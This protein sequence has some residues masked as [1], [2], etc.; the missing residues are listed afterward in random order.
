MKRY[1]FLVKGKI[2]SKLA[3]SI[4]EAESFLLPEIVNPVIFTITKV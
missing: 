1:N 4:E 2:I 3:F